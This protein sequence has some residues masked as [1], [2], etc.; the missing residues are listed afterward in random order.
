MFLASIFLWH[1]GGSDDVCVYDTTHG[2]RGGGIV[3]GPSEGK[4]AFHS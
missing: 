4:C 1:E 2:V 3:S